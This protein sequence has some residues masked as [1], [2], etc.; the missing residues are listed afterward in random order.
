MTLGKLNRTEVRESCPAALLCLAGQLSLSVFICFHCG[1]WFKTT[2]PDQV[3]AT[4]IVYVAG[5]CPDQ[6]A[7]APTMLNKRV[8]LC[9]LRRRDGVGWRR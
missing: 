5:G 1:E 9:K 4:K 6:R 7:G 8:N 2:M 3:S